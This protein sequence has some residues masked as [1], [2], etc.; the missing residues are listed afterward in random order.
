MNVLFVCNG[1][2]ARS[3]EAEVFFNGLTKSHSA[4]SAGV[5]VVIGKPIHPLV[6]EVMDEIGYKMKDNF[7]KVVDEDLVKNADLIVSFKPKHELPEIV[8]AHKMIKY[9]SVPDP[10]HQSIEFHREVRDAVWLKINELIEE[11][12]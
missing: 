3:Q 6:I 7:R 1:N 5:N 2:V 12:G 9:W 4:K 11:M 10:R 8:Q